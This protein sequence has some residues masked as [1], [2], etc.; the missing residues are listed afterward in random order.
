MNI[1]I[2][3][4][5]GVGTRMG[6]DIPKQYINVMGK[7][8]ICYTIETF[9]KR[10]DIDAFVFVVASEWQICVESYTKDI[11]QD[12][13]FASPGDNRQHSIY[14]A[15]K[16]CRRH[17]V[18]DDSI[19]IVHD[20]VRPLVSNKIIDDCIEGCTTHDG[21]LPV[22]PV[23]DTIYMSSDRQEI[24]SLLD[25]S[26]LYAGQA[27]E[28]F[29]FGKYI[30][31]HDESSYEDICHINGSTEIAYKNGLHIKLVEGDPMNFKITTPEDLTSFETIIKSRKTK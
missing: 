25:R 27:P 8:I 10:N 1:A 11:Q 30:K 17:G 21:V 15:L 26:K 29:I 3:L 18:S 12:T 31:I 9:A 6:A 7:P 13:W 19:I 16:E 5:G 23:K 22:L 14:N 2:I 4:S 28:S 24:D 20:A